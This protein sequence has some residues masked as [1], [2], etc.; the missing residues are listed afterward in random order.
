MYKVLRTL[1][2]TVW[3][4][5]ILCLAYQ[6]MT[7]VFTA[8]WPG[9]TLIGV[10]YDLLG[11]DLASLINSLPFEVAIKT[12]YLLAT[13]ELAIAL[14]WMGAILFASAFATKIIFGK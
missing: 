6:C 10:F 3:V 5:C 14:W 8:S 9:L 2:L 7:W 12:T 11:L 1:G 13:T 4:G